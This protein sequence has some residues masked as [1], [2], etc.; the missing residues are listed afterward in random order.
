MNPKEA[1][2]IFIRQG[3]V[4]GEIEESFARRW[5][6]FNHN[7]Q[8]MLDIETLEHKSRRPDVLVDDELIVAFYDRLIPEGIS[9]GADFDKWR[10]EAERENKELL[11][12]KREDLM[13]HEAAGV[14]TEAF[15]AFD[16]ARWR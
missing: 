5:A 4:E 2:E 14:T 6:F 8:L 15:S 7:H 11:Y 16:Q 1:R 10:K 12:L 13:R 9:N 3:L